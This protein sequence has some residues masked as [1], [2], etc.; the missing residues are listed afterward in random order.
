MNIKKDNFAKV[1]SGLLKAYGIKFDFEAL[2]F[3]IYDED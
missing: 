1:T 2:L 3:C